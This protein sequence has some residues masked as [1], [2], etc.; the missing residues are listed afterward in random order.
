MMDVWNIVMFLVPL[1]IIVTH[2]IVHVI[3]K[4]KLHK[5]ST[6]KQMQGV[7]MMFGQFILPLL[8]TLFIAIFF[9][10]GERNKM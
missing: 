8:A 4:R 9:L 5:A 7:L 2:T 1:I 6:F 10:V 3:D